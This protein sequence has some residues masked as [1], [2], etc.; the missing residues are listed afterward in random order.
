MECAKVQRMTLFNMH[1][2]KSSRLDE[3]EQG[4]TQSIDQA[5]NYLKVGM[6]TFA[7]WTMCLFSVWLRGAVA[8]QAM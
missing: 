2:T 3:F 6:R 7:Q 5:G 8:G 4:Q 1:Y